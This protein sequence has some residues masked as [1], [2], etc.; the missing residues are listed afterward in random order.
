MDLTLVD[1]TE[2]QPA[3]I[4]DEVVIIGSQGAIQIAAEEVAAQIGTISYEVTCGISRRVP[5]VYLAPELKPEAQR[6]S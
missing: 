3:S 4:N 5:R 2:I 1:V 6:V